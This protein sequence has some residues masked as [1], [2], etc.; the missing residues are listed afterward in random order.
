MPLLRHVPLPPNALSSNLGRLGALLLVIAWFCFRQRSLARP[1]SA[2]AVIVVAAVWA[3]PLLLAP[4]YFS[5]DVFL[6]VANG[7]LAE[8]GLDPGEHPPEE[9]GDDVVLEKVGPGWHEVVT[10]YGPGATL[11][12]ET[13][14]RA[15]GDSI[16]AGV[17]LWRV[18]V[19]GGVVL[20][21]L[22]VAGLA[23]AYRVNLA[24]AL[25]LAI[26]GP[27][28]IVHLI[29]G[30]HNDALMVGLLACGLAVAA[31]RRHAR[32]LL[33]GA[34]LCGLAASFKAPAL[35]GAA[36]IG[37]TGGR[38]PLR[39]PSGVRLV[40]PNRL[41]KR[42]SRTVATTGVAVATVGIVGLV[43]R[44]GLGWV[45]GL[46][47]AGRVVSL[48]SV[49]TTVGL[50]LARLTGSALVVESTVVRATQT[51]FSVIGI[52]I[53]GALVFF[54]PTLGLAS[55]AWA[56][57]ALTLL[58]PA[59]APWYFPWVLPAAAVVLAGRRVWW[60]MV[61]AAVATLADGANLAL[62][63]ARLVFVAMAL[64][65]CAV[66]WRWWSGRAVRPA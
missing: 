30:I 29:G 55:L 4:P 66:V 40:V 9:L 61:V 53:V 10:A 60:P 26:A 65:L 39:R 20:L 38:P 14:V 7:R 64:T 37:W 15:T 35:V 58:G 45:G 25:V 21:G 49:S 1:V 23:R 44:A 27:L 17:L 18:W 57:A 28:T 12:S 13:T 16:P 22:G 34:A 62:R 51:V 6:Y 54:A 5:G 33:V 63:P 32:A 43:A 3:V 50:L 11:L 2:R 19:V 56:L 59:V 24:D 52:A 8:H 36:Y 46:S 42:A 48:L 41:M 31:R 47:A